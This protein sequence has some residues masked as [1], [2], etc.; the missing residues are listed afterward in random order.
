MQH[1]MMKM[2]QKQMERMPKQLVDNSHDM[3]NMKMKIKHQ[4]MPVRQ[5]QGRRF[6]PT[7]IT[8][9]VMS[10]KKAGREIMSVKEWLRRG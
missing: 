7:R 9:N 1:N 4:Q 3:M 5:R 2:K 8:D 10:A 6:T